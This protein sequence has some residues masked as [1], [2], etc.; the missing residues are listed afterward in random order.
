MRKGRAGQ[1][2][3]KVSL[4]VCTWIGPRGGALPKY[5]GYGIYHGKKSAAEK[6]QGSPDVLPF[7]K[8]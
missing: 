5:N 8:F 4:I 1:R 2:V 6:K 3:L 7:E